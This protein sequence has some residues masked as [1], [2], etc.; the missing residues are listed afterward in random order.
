MKHTTKKRIEHRGTGGRAI[1]GWQVFK[2]ICA[3][4]HTPVP[5]VLAGDFAL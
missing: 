4:A 3:I 1:V 5:P 2:P